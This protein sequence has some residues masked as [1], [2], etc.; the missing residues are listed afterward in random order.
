MATWKTVFNDLKLYEAEL[1][2]FESLYLE[3]Q[4]WRDRWSRCST[5]I[6]DTLHGALEVC[7]KQLFPNVYHLLQLGCVLPVTSCEAEHSFFAFRRV[8]T[9]FRSFMGEERLLSLCPMHIH[10][11]VHIN[12]HIVVEE[13]IRKQPRRLF[14]SLYHKESNSKW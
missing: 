8:K 14:S 6:P 1:P 13:F 9:V 2:W 10:Y 11:D 5:K 4:L 7:D 3:L 12:S